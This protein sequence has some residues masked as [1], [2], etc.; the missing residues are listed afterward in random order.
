M[1]IK[2][3]EKSIIDSH[4]HYYDE[5]FDDPVR[6]LKKLNEEMGVGAVINCAVDIPSAKQCVSISDELDFCHTAAGFHAGDIPD[7]NISAH[8]AELE[9]FIKKNKV[10]A[11]GEIGLDYYWDDSNKDRQLIFFEEQLKLAYRL[12]LPVIVHDRDAHNDTLTLLKKYTPTGVVHCFSGSVEMAREIIKLGMYIG[13]G[14]VVTFKNAKR[15]CEV[16]RDV[17][18][19]KILLETDAPYMAPEPMRGKTCHSGYIAYTAQKIAEIK[20]MD[21]QSVIDIAANN[22]RELFGLK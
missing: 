12:N 15:V 20:G 13:I 9:N 22:T 14:G 3:K 10:V 19:E 5:R 1:D 17:P 6:L 18:M 21:T 7:G 8:I 2:V 4:A 16:V 11:I